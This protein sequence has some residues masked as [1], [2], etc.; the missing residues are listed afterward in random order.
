MMNSDEKQAELKRIEALA[1]D[2]EHIRKSA[3]HLAGL[4]LRGAE[5]EIV[6]QKL[7]TLDDEIL[8]DEQISMAYRTLI[9]SLAREVVKIADELI[10]ESQLPDRGETN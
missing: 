1:S 8:E 2:T 6:E 10:R 7:S 5:E 9:E 4:Y 3:L